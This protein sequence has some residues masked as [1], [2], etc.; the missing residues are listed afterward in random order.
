VSESI[1]AEA[2][3]DSVGEAK[4]NALRELEQL[5]PSLDKSAVQF[6]V[7]SEG[8]RGILGVGYSPARVLASVDKSAVTETAGAAVEATGDSEPAARVRGALE[9]ITTALGVRCRIDIAE[10]EDGISAT[11]SGGDLG[12]LIG[13]HGATIDA[14]QVLAGA[15]ASRGEDG[16]VDVVVDAAGYRERRRR[17][18]EAVAVRSA[19]EA[20]RAGTRVELEPMTAAERRLVHERLKDYEGVSTV[21]EGEEPHRYVVVELA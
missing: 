10:D 21:S 20:L 2:T 7:L 13:K 19:E 18:L 5:V 4:W 16:R 1:T 17:T 14:V 3:G 8:H 6:Q 9:H 11:C 12:I 15:I